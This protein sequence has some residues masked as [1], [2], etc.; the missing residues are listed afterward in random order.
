VVVVLPSSILNHSTQALPCLAAVL[1]QHC[2]NKK[3]ALH[4]PVLLHCCLC[5][6]VTVTVLG[7][8]A[9]SC[10]AAE[11]RCSTG[12]Q[13]RAQALHPACL[14]CYIAHAHCRQAATPS[15]CQQWSSSTLRF[16]LR[17]YGPVAGKWLAVLLQSF[18]A[19][20]CQGDPNMR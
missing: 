1:S 6:A 18:V 11:P 8:Q 15:R 3:Q 14:H 4:H 19:A 12:F 17:C 7:R 13:G 2:H 9:V 16:F 20:A 5:R 10:A